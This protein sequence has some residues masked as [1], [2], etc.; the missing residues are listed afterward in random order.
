[1]LAGPKH[2]ISVPFS[3]GYAVPLSVDV[4][5]V[6][7]VP[8]PNPAPGIALKLS[9]PLQVEIKSDRCNKLHS[10]F[11]FSLQVVTPF[12]SPVTVQLK[13]KV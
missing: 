11:P 4:K 3:A 5:E 12:M 2:S 6:A 8:G 9:L 13:L 10:M 7:V 1:M